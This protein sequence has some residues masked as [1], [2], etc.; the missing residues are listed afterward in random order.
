MSQTRGKFITL[1]G[2]EGVGKTTNQRVIEAFLE[3]KSIPFITTREPGG[4]LLA[5][6]IRT[7]LLTP[8]EEKISQDAELLLMF[9]S[10]S[11]HLTERI[12]PALSEGKWV[13]CS[14]FTDSTYAYQG[15]GRGI[16]SER[17]AVLEQWVQGD[18][19][20]DLTFIFDLPVEV[21]LARASARG[22]LDR[23]EQENVDFFNRVRRVFLDRAQRGSR[24]RKIDASKPLEAVQ[25]DL[26][27][28]LSDF[29]G[30]IAQ[31]PC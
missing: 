5:E 27:S 3:S 7:L 10:R 25:L 9:A 15:G 19:Q 2:V 29:Y 22:E 26:L 20:P 12:L 14:R 13:I 24:Y 16:P 23:I 17:I 21:G 6:R 4:T 30:L 8:S 18:F 31:S 1:E 28:A 11:Q